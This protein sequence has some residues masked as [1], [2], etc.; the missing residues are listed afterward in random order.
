[1]AKRLSQEEFI[2]RCNKVHNNFYDYSKTIYN[3]KREKITV[4]CPIHGE[5]NITASNH[6]NGQ[7]CS[8]CSSEH[9][10]M[11]SKWRYE[12]FVEKA[13]ILFNNKYSF[14]NIKAEYE[15]NKSIITIICNDCGN[16]FTKRANDFLSSKDGGCKT[17]RDKNKLISYEELKSQ[18]NE[19][20]LNKFDGLKNINN[21]CVDLTCI[22]NHTFS[23]KI[24]KILNSTYRCKICSLIDT[25]HKKVIDK[26]AFISKFNK[27]IND[28]SITP[29]ISEYV[30]Y[31]T[32][33]HFK[34]NKCGH[35]FKRKPSSFINQK[36]IDLCPNCSKKIN[37]LNKTKTT[38]EYINECKLIYPN[39]EYNF[40]KT[41]YNGSDKK[42][43]IKCN[44]CG[45]EFTIE[46][47]SFLQGHGCPYHYCNMSKKEREISDYI[48]SLGFETI[49]NDKKLLNG[50]EID[51]FVP[52]INLA[53][54]FNGIY[55]H[56]ELNKNK[57]YHLEK[58]IICKNKG[59]R[60]IHIFE[61]EWDD[62]KD[63][64]K[65]MLKNLCDLTEIK[66]YGRKC[67]IKEVSYKDS[68]TFLNNNH[69]QGK[70]NSKIRLGLYYN[71]ELVSLMTF[72]NTRHFIG[73][74][75]HQYELLR[76]CNKLNTN[77]IGGAS[78]L[79]KHFI[80]TYK[81]KNIV[82]YADRRW[83]VGNLYN[84]LGFKLYNISKPS[85]YY[86]INN[87]RKNRFN[88]RKGIL[89]KKYNC[90]KNMS[91]HEFCLSKKWYRI[92]DCG[93]LCYEINL[94]NNEK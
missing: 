57:N 68:A 92:Y 49:L 54:E 85:Y 56:N 39:D 65:S 19:F 90:P 41:V 70:C 60:L 34:C 72:G 66:I 31:Q 87:K 30:D 7:G 80:K 71:D 94:E 26:D 22:H 15:N 21:D 33:I 18:C 84:T 27:L 11:D 74:S 10:K 51:I 1:M 64:L 5:F 36:F 48:N 13:N 81:P 12:L 86:I 29:F 73:N 82:S 23:T 75:S 93:C 6:M 35:I 78:K 61:D 55:W 37:S 40:S 89:V 28:N 14:P 16:T 83:S 20:T 53:I 58:T 44:S 45:K 25:N 52:S 77:V 63:I 50:K 32:P 24:S 79:L 4:I 47:N 2:E 46:A 76:F 88:F 69:L 67:I 38:E 42:V 91:E 62:K 59:I 43:T 3:N 17:C 9:I 8:K